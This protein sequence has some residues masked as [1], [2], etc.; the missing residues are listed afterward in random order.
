[1]LHGRKHRIE[2]GL[3]GMGKFCVGLEGFAEI[4]DANLIRCGECG[5]RRRIRVDN[6]FKVD[7]G[8]IPCGGTE[9]RRCGGAEVRMHGCTDARITDHGCTDASGV[10]KCREIYLHNG[11]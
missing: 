2:R 7:Y 1:M 9:V 3:L 6:G 8:E 4:L 10:P 11:F 5:T